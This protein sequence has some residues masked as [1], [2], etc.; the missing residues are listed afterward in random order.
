MFEIS[1]I[2]PMT[3]MIERIGGMKRLCPNLNGE[4]APPHISWKFQ[5]KIRAIIEIKKLSSFLVYL[6]VK[7][8]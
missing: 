5:Y 8:N 7:V 3:K 4:K 1:T 2:A 6:L